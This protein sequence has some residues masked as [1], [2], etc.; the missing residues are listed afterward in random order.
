MADSVPTT[1]F[2]EVKQEVDKAVRARVP[3]ISVAFNEL[4][5]RGVDDQTAGIMAT[6]IVNMCYRDIDERIQRESRPNLADRLNSAYRK[7]KA[8]IYSAKWIYGD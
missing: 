5:T 8:L 1:P 3:S 7:G 4:T 2:A 6:I